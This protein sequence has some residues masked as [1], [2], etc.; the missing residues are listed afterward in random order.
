MLV[1]VVYPDVNDINKLCGLLVAEPRNVEFPMLVGGQECLCELQ[2]FRRLR[3][4]IQEVLPRD[5]IRI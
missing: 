1:V 4:S 3:V 5:P 2:E